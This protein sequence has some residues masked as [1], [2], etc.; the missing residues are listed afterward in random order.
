[1]QRSGLS[2]FP[3]SLQEVYIFEAMNKVI[4]LG[5]VFFKSKDP[6]K[7]REWYKKHLGMPVET[8]GCMFMFDS[9]EM[10]KVSGYNIWSPFKEESTKFSP[11][12]K[13]FMFNFIVADLDALLADLKKEGVYV[14]EESESGEYGKFGWIMDPEDNKIELWQPP[15][16]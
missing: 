8:W 2:I 5:G 10:E 4:G 14:F 13:P 11:S 7:L 9:P 1:M 6:E 15:A 12:S 16:K 3:G